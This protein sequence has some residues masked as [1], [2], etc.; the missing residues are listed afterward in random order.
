MIV[1]I[2]HFALVLAFA[3]SLVLSVVPLVGARIGD[4][5]LMGIAEPASISILALIA[6]SFAALTVAYVQSDFS[7]ANVWENSHSAKP[8]LYKITGVWGNH[9][10]SMLL[11]ILI[12]AAFA[13]LVA[14]FGGNLP[15]TLRAN[16]LAVQGMIAAAFLLFLLASANPFERISPPPIE[17]PT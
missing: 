9:E 3:L 14:I 16:V 6:L 7:V 2:G 12:L 4:S 13:A 17:K 15:A 11:W 8:M 10:G 1:E 5:R